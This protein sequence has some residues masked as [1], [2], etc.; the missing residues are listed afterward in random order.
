[1]VESVINCQD[2]HEADVVL[3]TAPYDRTVSFRKGAVNG[4]AAIVRC[5]KYQVELFDSRTF[6]VPAENLKVAE[7]FV[8]FFPDLNELEPAVMVEM[9]E[10]SCDVLLR[11]GKFV[12]LL[13]GEHSVS[14][15]MFLALREFHK[16]SEVTIL[17]I[18]AHLDLRDDDSD[19]SDEFHRHGKYSHACVMRR[20]VELGYKV[21][22]VGARA[23]SREEYE[24]ARAN[25]I[26]YFGGELEVCNFV[27][28]ILT[29]IIKEVTTE[30]VYLSI[31]ADGIDPAHMPA[32][33]TPV[34]GGLGWYYTLALVQQIFETKNVIG[35]DLVEVAPRQD[36]VLTEFAA[37]QLVH[38]II[39]CHARK[40]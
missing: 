36:D 20:A 12:I 33:G 18:D 10:E 14:N 32:V 40:R 37:A 3:L 26:T 35:A 6:T 15:G 11:R 23:Y 28:A 29:R 7:E 31:D 17:T 9:V 34:P 16:P 22:N 24:F 38:H 2:V 21:V 25:N 4:P 8:L 13:G 5:L 19:F 1:M 39:S 30:K 27:P